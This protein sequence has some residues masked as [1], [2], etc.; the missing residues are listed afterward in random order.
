[1]EHDHFLVEREKSLVRRSDLHESS[2]FLNRW[3][4]RIN[5]PGIDND[6]GDLG[7]ENQEKVCS[8]CTITS[9]T[10][11]KLG[12]RAE[13]SNHGCLYLHPY[14][15]SFEPFAHYDATQSHML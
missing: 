2:T 15:A 14:D 11:P 7:H 5:E 10:S 8:R 6:F 3:Y 13:I 12:N 9:F 1:M 4:C